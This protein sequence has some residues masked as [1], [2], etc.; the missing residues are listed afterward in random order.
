L[1]ERGHDVTFISGF[2]KSPSDDPS[3]S[4]IRD[5]SS[6]TLY[7]LMTKS[8]DV[9]RFQERER[10]DFKRMLTGYTQISTKICE[11]TLLK[12][13]N[14]QVLQNLW[15]NETFDL[16]IINII[17]GECGFAFAHRYNAKTIVYDASVTLSWYEILIH[18]T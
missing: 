18:N 10:G 9:D 6:P 17:Y 13:E 15:H 2:E 11:T 4:K 8:Y 1:A 14:D 7:T 16:V 3:H 5:L 12:S